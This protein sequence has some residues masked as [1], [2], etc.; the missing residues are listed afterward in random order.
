MGGGQTRLFGGNESMW[1]R[2]PGRVPYPSFGISTVSATPVA[3]TRSV[4][5]RMSMAVILVLP[6]SCHQWQER[7][8][9]LIFCHPSAM[10]AA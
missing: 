10:L 2:G 8:Y 3:M 6:D 4:I 7:Q 9:A 5:R 1:L